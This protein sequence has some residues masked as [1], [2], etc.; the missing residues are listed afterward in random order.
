MLDRLQAAA[1]ARRVPRRA[2]GRRRRPGRR[3]RRR[4]AAGPRARRR[5]GRARPEPRD[6][7]ARRRRR[8]RRT[9]RPR[10]ENQPRSRPDDRPERA[11][12]GD[13]APGAGVHRHADPLRGGGRAGRRR[14]AGR[15]H[16]EVPPRGA[17]QR[18]LR[19]QHARRRWAVR[20][21]PRCSRCWCRSR[22]AGSPTGSRGACTRRRSGGSR[23]RPTSSSS[24]GC[25]RRSRGERHECYAITE[26]LAG[27]DVSDL[28]TTA[29]RD[30][31]DY[32]VNGTKWHVTSY[33][34][35][36]Y[37]FVQAVLTDGPNAGEH[38][39]LVVDLPEPGHRG[40][41]HAGVLPQHRR[42]PPD[43]VLHRRARPRLAA[44]RRARARG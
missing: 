30:G 40:G 28:A 42:P 18:P 21:S 5:A 26:E 33:N 24:A 35:A 10:T 41:P 43:R 11:G 3:G 6:R 15:A 16:R 7:D 36:D 20:A 27:T 44:D 34:V 32:V 37:C 25:G 29:R 22:S 4:V 31:D 38:V 14:A 12:P 2:A 9:D 1:A 17:R 39:L 23:S 8:G 19:D 13:P